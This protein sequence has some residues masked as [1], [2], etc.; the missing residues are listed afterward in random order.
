MSARA[1]AFDL[2]ILRE[3]AGEKVFARGQAYHRDGR[4]EILAI[5]SGRVLARVAGSENYRV[6][7]TGQGE[8]IGGKCSCP[9]FDDWGCCKHM[10]AAALGANASGGNAG[11]AGVGALARIREHLRLKD[12]DALVEMILGLAERDPTLF[13]NL[14]MAASLAVGDARTL[15]ANLTRAI[16]N[17]TRTRGFVEYGEA[18]GWAAGVDDV[19]EV[20]AELTPTGHAAQALELAEH[21]IDRIEAAIGAI[22]DSDG[23]CGALLARARDIHLAA[24]RATR[25]EPTEFARLLFAREMEGEYDTFYGAV[26]LYEA[27]LGEQGLA[28]YRR[29]ALEA[30]TKLPP[31]TGGVAGRYTFDSGNLALRTALDFFAEREGDVDARIALRAKDLSSPWNY[32]QLAE[33]CLSQGRQDEALRRAEEGLW[34]FED[35]Q[36]DERLVVFAAE[37]LAKSGRSDDAAGVLWRAFERVPSLELYLSLRA[38]AGESACVRAVEFLRA[39]VAR[40]PSELRR[41]TA[42]LLVAI[43]ANDRAFDAAWTTVREHGAST[44][45]KEALARASERTHPREAIE[46]Y[47]ERIDR[48]AERG[49]NSSYEEAVKLLDRMAA[50]RSSAEQAAHVEALKVRFG[51]KRNFVK[52][53]K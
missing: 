19:L 32:L 29:L 18:G 44:A 4:V 45:A 7:I 25:P 48:L 53:L 46:V 30:W 2:A 31:R 14:D 23:H 5:E 28:E 36:P 47:A 35:R 3:R 22:D 33:F 17:A 39:Q 51:R 10:V 11:A 49:G 8:D 1:A 50:L 13:R 24:A 41:Q 16:E 27:V 26:R 37:L 38:L 15:S 21:A 12:V 42:D 34:V 9:A 52:L 40:R 20:L 6:E 43:L